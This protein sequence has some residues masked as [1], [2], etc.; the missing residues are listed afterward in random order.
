LEFHEPKNIRI[1]TVPTV[2]DSLTRNVSWDE[3]VVT[4]GDEVLENNDVFTIVEFWRDGNLYDNKK[5]DNS[6]LTVKLGDLDWST[7]ISLSTATN[8]FKGPDSSQKQLFSD[9]ILSHPKNIKISYSFKNGELMAVITWEN[10]METSFKELQT[11][12]NIEDDTD[13]EV[14]ESPDRVKRNSGDEACDSSPKLVPF[15]QTEAA[16][17]LDCIGWDKDI[18]LQTVVGDVKGDPSDK[19]KLFN[20]DMINLDPPTDIKSSIQSSEDGTF[21]VTL[22]W[23]NPNVF[24]DNTSPP[25]KLKLYKDATDTEPIEFLIDES[26]SEYKIPLGDIKPWE[27]KYSLETNMRSVSGVRSSNLEELVTEFTLYPPDSISGV[28]CD[29][30]DQQNCHIS[31]CYNVT[32]HFQGLGTLIK[33]WNSTEIQI[34][35]IRLEDTDKCDN[36]TFLLSQI[37]GL[38][39][40]TYLTL[41]SVLSDRFISGYSESI[42]VVNPQASSQED[43]FWLIL[44]IVLSILLLLYIIA[45]ILCLYTAK[46]KRKYPV[47]DEKNGNG[48]GENGTFKQIKENNNP[49]YPNSDNG[50][51]NTEEESL[52]SNGS[53]PVTRADS[54][55]TLGQFNDDDDFMGH[56]DEDG[57]FIGDYTEHD[58]ETSLAVKNKLL[59]FSQLYG[60][61]QC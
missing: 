59:Y 42:A 13:N 36:H 61:K 7:S 1:V 33:F 58:Q 45:T 51:R 49:D 38:D 55:I 31:W 17:S 28:S 20:K 25:L 40:G 4:V 44:G 10:T 3:G 43:N 9:L 37:E 41:Q 56:F 57:S 48:L 39:T 50:S 22:T 26:T 5:E 23:T 11:M 60:N 53:V 8:N 19:V 2:D 15:S 30:N 21:E 35:E 27:V 52:L 14:V 29:D 16:F 47:S 32:S 12:I 54:V 6:S 18:S 46:R 24:D 34:D